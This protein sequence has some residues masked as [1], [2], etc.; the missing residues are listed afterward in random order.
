MSSKHTDTPT[1]HC[2][3][4]GRYVLAATIYAADG[5]L[6]LAPGVSKADF[7]EYRQQVRQPWPE[8]D[9]PSASGSKLFSLA[10]PASPSASG[11]SPGA[12]SLA[13]FP[14]PKPKNDMS[15]SDAE[16]VYLR[17][18]NVMQ[19]RRRWGV[20]LLCHLFN[21]VEETAKER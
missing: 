10:T 7:V 19:R 11:S 21:V 14:F 20:D 5:G 18:Q 6:K 9:V 12:S 15:C 8:Q 2:L 4:V 3:K 1:A 17:G 16:E 13:C